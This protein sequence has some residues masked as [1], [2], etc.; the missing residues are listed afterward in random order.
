[1][2]N[3][4]SEIIK[5]SYDMICPFWLNLYN[6]MYET[7]DYPL[8]WGDTCSIISPIFK[9]GDVMFTVALHSSIY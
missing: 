1:M 6:H 7:G 4:T 2:D 9:K 3:I 5:A 8:S